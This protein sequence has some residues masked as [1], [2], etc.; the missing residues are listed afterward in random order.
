MVSLQ[1]LN[2]VKYFPCQL[3]TYQASLTPISHLWHPHLSH[4]RNGQVLNWTVIKSLL[5]AYLYST[6]V[7][8]ALDAS[9]KYAPN[10]FPVPDFAL[11][12]GSPVVNEIDMVPA[13]KNLQTSER[14]IKQANPQI[15]I[16]LQILMNAFNKKTQ[17]N[18][19]VEWKGI[20]VSQSKEYKWWVI[21]FWKPM[22][23]ILR[24]SSFR[25]IKSQ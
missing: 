11:S 23:V 20:W 17:H 22:H 21:R 25:V 18:T 9:Q 13:S 14:N 4:Y 15:I 5:Y 10:A 1:P 8:W 24:T 12:S 7:H 19:F 2:L 16:R 3:M 6:D